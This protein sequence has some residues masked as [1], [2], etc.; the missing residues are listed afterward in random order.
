MS[1][2]IAL[3]IDY[4]HKNP[5]SKFFRQLEEETLALANQPRISAMKTSPSLQPKAMTS[6]RKGWASRIWTDWRM[7]VSER[8]EF[9]W[10]SQ[11][12]MVPDSSPEM[13]VSG[14][15]TLQLIV[16]TLQRWNEAGMALH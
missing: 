15:G 14:L 13:T 8:V 9:S 6:A 11:T 3:R 16:L 5:I 10:T 12:T 4:A 7:K 1:C 2:E